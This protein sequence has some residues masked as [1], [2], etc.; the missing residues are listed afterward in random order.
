MP[1]RQPDMTIEYKNK[2]KIFLI[3]LACPSKINMNAKHAE[4]LQKYQQSHSRSDRDDRG[5]I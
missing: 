4:K 2:N 5:T 3:D 1:A